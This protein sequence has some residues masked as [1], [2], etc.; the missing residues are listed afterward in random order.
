MLLTTEDLL[1]L[2]HLAIDAAQKAGSLISEYST[3]D[4]TVNN[5]EAADSL[6]SQVVTEVD[7][8]AQNAILEI[9]SP[10]IAKYDLA[11]LTEESTDDKSRFQKDY[12]LVYRPNGRHIG[13]YR[14]NTRFCSFHC[15]GFKIRRTGYWRGFRSYNATAVSC[16]KKSGGF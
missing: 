10:S 8:K 9:L 16:N 4:V 13:I 2:S 7:V 6:A 1:S 14:K 3:K 5:K 11:L 15:A 12:F